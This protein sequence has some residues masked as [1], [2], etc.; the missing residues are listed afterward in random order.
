MTGLYANWKFWRQII[1]VCT[2][3]FVGTGQN[4]TVCRQFCPRGRKFSCG[5][6]LSHHGTNLSQHGTNLSHHGQNCV[7]DFVRNLPTNCEE[8][9]FY[10]FFW[11]QFRIFLIFFEKSLNY[12]LVNFSE[13]VYA[14]LKIWRQ[15]FGV[16]RQNYDVG[17]KNKILEALLPP[18][19]FFWKKIWT[20]FLGIL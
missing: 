11:R 15:I 12:S 18:N 20:E 4:L 10:Q 6:N 14:I 3:F 1:H 9:S 13:I 7:Q 8:N 5:T 17:G 16:W 19:L 2:Q